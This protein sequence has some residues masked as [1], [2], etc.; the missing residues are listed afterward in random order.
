VTIEKGELATYIKEKIINT[1]FIDLDNA[2][3]E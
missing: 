1:K 3:W 2:A